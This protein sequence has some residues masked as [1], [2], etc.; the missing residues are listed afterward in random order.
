MAFFG[1]LVSGIVKVALS[2]I[3]IAKD[4]VDV[5]IGE[6]PE[7]TKKLLSSAGDDVKDSIDDLEE[8]NLL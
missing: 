5:A 2:P 4:V 8:G 7:N 3:A 1:N 6:E